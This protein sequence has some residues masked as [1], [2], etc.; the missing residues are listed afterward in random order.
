[1]L[2]VVAVSAISAFLVPPCPLP[3]VSRGIVLS[4]A[5]TGDAPEEYI[6][7]TFD[8]TLESLLNEARAS[9]VETAVDGWLD[10]LDDNFIPSLGERLEAP[11]HADNVDELKA[12][13]DDLTV[14]SAERFSR[15]K[16]QLETLLEAGEINKLDAQLVGLMKRDELDGGF[17]YVLFKNMEDAQE[18]NDEMRMRLL[19]HLHTRVQEELEKKADP[20]LAL[21]HKLT[22]TDDAGIR[23]RILRHYLTPA[24]STTLP[25]GTE[26]PLNPPA[27]AQVTPLDF[28]SAV[29]G[30]L[31]KVLA[32]SVDRRVLEA[33]AEDIRGVAKEAH[34]VVVEAYPPSEVEQFQDALTPVFARALPGR[35]ASG[36]EPKMHD[37]GS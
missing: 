31:D 15:A 28:A 3:R 12:L 33:T 2:A 24:T 13:M 18:S 7:A 32:M 10:R 35:V 37:S 4:A 22:R 11:L 36:G 25:D 30:A 26:L 14:R 6:G 27:P 17:L 9:S 5:A 29:E 21:L 19:Q 8:R 1:M 23:G 20:G 16:Q 34:R